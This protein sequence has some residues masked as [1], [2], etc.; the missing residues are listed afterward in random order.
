MRI[1]QCPELCFWC[2]ETTGQLSTFEAT[3]QEDY[4]VKGVWASYEPCPSCRNTW[5]L[6]IVLF[7]VLDHQVNQRPP[8][9]PGYYPTGRWFLVP[10]DTIME[11]FTYPE[12]VLSSGKGI[13]DPE[14]ADYLMA[15]FM[16]D[17]VVH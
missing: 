1:I 16:E 6:G 14:I 10:R 2:G 11:H 13:I 12:R 17:Q 5:Q 8:L 3:S 15:S 7:E 9:T 4:D